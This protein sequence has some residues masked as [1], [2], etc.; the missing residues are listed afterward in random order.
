MVNGKKECGKCGEILPIDNFTKSK[1]GYYSSKCKRCVNEYGKQYRSDKDRKQ[2]MREYHKKYM[3][4]RKNRDTKNEYIRKYR[5]TEK[6]KEKNVETNRNWKMKEKQKA[7]SYL[8][9]KCSICGYD[10][11]LTALEF[12]HINPS[13]KEMY[14]SHWKFERNIP[15]L[16]KC[17][18]VCAN[19][20]RE[21]HAKEIWK[22]E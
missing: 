17:I 19:C 9:G 4:N 2:K 1:G 11:C 13:E 15:E 21:I 10:K 14:N 6:A 16:N 22:N 20:H 5:K 18:L 7:V 3:S 8:G 12:H